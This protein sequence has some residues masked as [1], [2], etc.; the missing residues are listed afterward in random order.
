MFDALASFSSVASRRRPTR[1]FTLVEILIVVVILG[2]LAAIVVPKLSNASQVARENTLQD[3]IRFLRTQITV[4]SAQHHDVC[5]GYP[6]GNTASSPTAADML[7]QLTTYTDEIGNTSTTGSTIFCY[8]PYLSRM[9][10]NPV[11]SL[12]TVTIVAG[13]GA[14]TPDGTSGWLY[15]PLTGAILPNLL[16][17]D[18]TGEDFSSY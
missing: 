17:A 4:Y 11:N 16:G 7:A 5:P 6:G 10:D 2:I 3:D 1:G 9:P 8:G 15:Q 13:T 12:S 14:L 18:S